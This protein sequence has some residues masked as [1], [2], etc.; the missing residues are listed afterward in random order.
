M[1]TASTAEG[2]SSKLSAPKSIGLLNLGDESP[3]AENILVCK[4]CM[5]QLQFVTISWFVQ[6]YVLQQ[7][8]SCKLHFE[9]HKCIIH[10]WRGSC[11]INDHKWPCK[12]WTSILNGFWWDNHDTSKKQMNL[13]L[14]YWFSKQ[15]R[16]MDSVVHF[17]SVM[18]KMTSHQKR[19]TVSG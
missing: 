10:H 14:R 8:N 18:L 3:K 9:S 2:S 17:S 5:L 12:V 11:T 13:T 4:N 19:C 16:S 6:S 7:Q 15:W 1:F